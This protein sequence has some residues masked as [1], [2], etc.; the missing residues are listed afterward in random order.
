MIFKGNIVLVK[1]NIIMSH[2]NCYITQL[3]G[4]L[5]ERVGPRIGPAGLSLGLSGMVSV[6]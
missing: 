6:G 4:S 5:A 1:W 3:P 2:Y